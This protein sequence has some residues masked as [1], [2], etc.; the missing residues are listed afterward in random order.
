MRLAMTIYFEALFLG[1]MGC[2]TSSPVTPTPGQSDKLT[3]VQ[4]KVD[5]VTSHIGG[6]TGFGGTNMTNYLV[7]MP[8]HMGFTTDASL[9][10]PNGHVNVHLVNGS[11]AACTVHLT[12]FDS[13][14]GNSEQTQDVP[15]PANG[16]ATVQIPC[17]EIIGTGSLETPGTAACRLANGSDISNMMAL[18]AFL[19]TDYTCGS[20]YQMTVTPDVNNLMGTGNTSQLIMTSGAMVRHMESMMGIEMMR[21]R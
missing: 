8:E 21:R 4:E 2:G 12:Y 19:G 14:L 17:S 10:D 7:G 11:N 13:N 15:V 9:A 3:A 1:L 16:D 20:T 18:P 6:P 5:A